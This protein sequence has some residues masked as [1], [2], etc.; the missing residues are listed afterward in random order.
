MVAL[1]YLI[2]DWGNTVM[3]DLNLPGPMKDW[4]R[5]ENIPG[6][7]RTLGELSGSY[8]LVIATS[9]NH[10][11]TEDMKKALERGGCDTFF[12][13]FFSSREL[14][15]SKPNPEFFRQILKKLGCSPLEALSVGDKYPNDI[16]AAKYLGLYTVWFNEG[17]SALP[18]PDADA[19]IYH[20]KDLPDAIA[21]ILN[22]I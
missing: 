12:S 7:I 10:S 16:Q 13:H 3:R 19:L 15:A 18:H 2:F 11:N 17:Q 9:A 20:M 8:T 4:D 21:G 14:G 5:V 22:K 6:I 1:K